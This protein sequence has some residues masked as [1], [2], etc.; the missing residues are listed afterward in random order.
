MTQTKNSDQ[1]GGEN[2]TEEEWT[3]VSMWNEEE[4]SVAHDLGTSGWSRM[5]FADKGIPRGMNHLC[6]SGLYLLKWMSCPHMVLSVRADAEL[7]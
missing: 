6:S 1:V 3:S 4:G 7:L 2:C 5:L